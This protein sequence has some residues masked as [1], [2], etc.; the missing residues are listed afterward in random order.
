MIHLKS[1]VKVG[2][3]G[4]NVGSMQ[5]KKGKYRL[6]GEG[7][8]LFFKGK[9]ENRDEGSTSRMMICGG[10]ESARN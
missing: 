3:V 7:L 1:R 9:K 2:S 5:E 6:Q 10:E 8:N 4:N